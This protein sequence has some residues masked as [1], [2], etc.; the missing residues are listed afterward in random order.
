MTDKQ[1]YNKQRKYINIHKHKDDDIPKVGQYD[2]FNLF[3][4]TALQYMRKA[5]FMRIA[6]EQS[7]LKT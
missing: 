6:F 1:C 7:I 2:I 4:K 5:T 3:L